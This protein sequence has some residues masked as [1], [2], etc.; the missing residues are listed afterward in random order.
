MNGPVRTYDWPSLM[1][2]EWT[3]TRDTLHMWA[4]IVGKIRMVHM[5]LINHWWQATLYVSPR[6]L[7]TGTV[8]YRDAAF[9]IEFDFVNQLLA[10]RHSDGGHEAVPLAAK[11]VAEFYGATLSA[12]DSLGIESHIV[13]QPNEV[14]PAIP[15]AEDFQHSEYEPD[16][17]RA[18][19]Q[20]LVQAY[21]VMMNFR[22]A[23]VGKA[24]PVQFF[25][26]A[27]DLAC[28]RF[29]G[30]P[31]PTH[32]GGVP[33]CPDWVMVEGYSRELSSCGFWPGGGK[34]GA[35]YSYA[36]P[37][38]DGFSAH[39]VEPDTAYYSDEY[40]EFLLPYEA[41]RTADDPD[42][43]LARFLQTTYEAAAELGGWDR[44]ALEDDP[45]R[46]PPRSPR[47]A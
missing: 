2:D 5:P 32:P 20:Q 8:P 21:R 19:W 24:S 17:A 31:A 36:Y 1:V 4:Q 44:S 16:A 30:R 11:P 27:M 18:F 10:I 14:D 9:D 15:F 22:A 28:T 46:L 25:W 42:R 38:P 37:K 45:H 7:T 3:P 26:G 23:F 35:F 39:R 47:R 12:L 40:Q 41:V 33:N 34:E 13:S 43:A 29:S 6:G